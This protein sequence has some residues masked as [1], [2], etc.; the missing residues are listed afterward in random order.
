MTPQGDG[1]VAAPGL[2]PVGAH[3]CQDPDWDECLVYTP[4]GGHC[5]MHYIRAEP[6]Q[7]LLNLGCSLEVS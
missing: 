3:W 6:K 1:K 4:V 7:L 2:R 5:F